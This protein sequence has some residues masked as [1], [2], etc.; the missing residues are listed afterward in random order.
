MTWTLSTALIQCG[1]KESSSMVQADGLMAGGART[2]TSP[3]SALDIPGRSGIQTAPAHTGG[4]AIPSLT[5][6]R[7]LDD[8][9]HIHETVHAALDGHY[10]VHSAATGSRHRAGTPA[11]SPRPSDRPAGTSPPPPATPRPRAAP[12]PRPGSVCWQRAERGNVPHY[13]RAR[14]PGGTA[15]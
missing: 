9:L 15:E 14:V 10:V 7:V 4:P 5:L 13:G 8:D 3:H 6:P 12:I 11:L 2:A 1:E